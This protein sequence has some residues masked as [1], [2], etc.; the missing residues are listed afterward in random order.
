MRKR[1]FWWIVVI[2]WCSMIYM[3]TA[4]PWST[5]QSTQEMIERTASASE[6]SSEIIN[7]AVRKSTHLLAFGALAIFVLLALQPSRKAPIIA[8]FFA[9]AYGA[10]DEFHQSFIPERRASWVDVGIDSFGALL[11]IILVSIVLKRRNKTG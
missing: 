11:A 9:T 8:W 3:F 4:S 1:W 7:V 5:G 6:Q 2:L 10:M